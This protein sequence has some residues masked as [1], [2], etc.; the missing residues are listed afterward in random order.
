M[1][2]IHG[3]C[4]PDFAAVKAAFEANF[5]TRDDIGASVAVSFEGEMVVDL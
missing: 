2:A 4:A 5:A 3:T 1:T